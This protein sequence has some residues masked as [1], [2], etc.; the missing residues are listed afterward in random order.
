MCCVQAAQ[1]IQTLQRE[2]DRLRSL[3]ICL[4]QQRKA[5]IREVAHRSGEQAAELFL[6]AVG[7][8]KRSDIPSHEESCAETSCP[9]S[10]GLRFM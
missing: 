1:E 7:A 8:F 10:A 9:L 5:Y 2:T 6:A 4:I 3:K